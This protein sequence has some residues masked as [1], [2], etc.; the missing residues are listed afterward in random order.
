MDRNEFVDMLTSD[1]VRI[2]VGQVDRQKTFSIHKNLFA[3]KAPVFYKMFDGGFKEGVTGL[4]TLP[5]DS[6]EAFEN[7]AQWLYFPSAET[8]SSHI[9]RNLL[10]QENSSVARWELVETIVFANKYCL[11]ALSDLAMSSWIIHQRSTFPLEELRKI[12]SYIVANTSHLCKARVGL[13]CS[14]MGMA[15][16]SASGK[17][18][19]QI[20]YI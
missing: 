19:L 14:H 18:F 4:A 6:H 2:T 16:T 3:K 17:G 20:K 5:Y 10:P 7:F 13:L 9:V 15:Y 12:T 1:I 11:D 8:F